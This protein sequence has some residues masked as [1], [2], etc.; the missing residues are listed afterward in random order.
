MRF[1]FVLVTATFFI[2]G[3]TVSQEAAAV[4]KQYQA[5]KLKQQPPV[6]DGRLDETFWQTTEKGGQFVQFQPYEGRQPSQLT[7]FAI[8]YDDNNLYVAYWCYDTSPDSI[9]RRLTRRDEIDGDMVGIDIDSYYDKRTSFGFF[10]NAA[11]VKLDQVTSNNGMAEDKSWDPNWYVATAITAQGWTA[12]M[13]IPLS[14]LRFSDKENRIWGIEVVRQI[15]RKDEM[16][17]WQP[18]PRNAPGSVYMYGELTGIS[19]IKPRRQ[20]DLTPYA[21]ASGEKFE[22]EEGNPYATGK[23]FKY[24]AGLDAKIG[25]TNN[26][27][28]D[29]SVNPDFGQVEADPSQVNLTAFETFFAEKRPFFVEGRNILSMPLMLGDG[30]LANENLFYTRRVGRKPQ[31]YPS[32]SDG[33]YA[34]VP[35]FSRI[36]GAAKISGR[37]ENGWS[38]GLLES[39]AAEEKAEIDLSGEKRYETVEPLTNYLIGTVRKDMNEGNTVI[40]GMI[41][42]TN[43]KLDET[44]L[45][46]LHSG[47]YTAGLDFTQYFKDKAYM[48]MAKTYFSQVNGS[49][50]AITQTQL[51]SAR[52][53]QRPDVT[54]IHLDTTRTSLFGNG[55]TLFFGKLGNSPLQWGWFL[56][57]KT[58]GVELND[59]GYMRSADNIMPIFWAGY[60][61]TKPFGIFRSISMNTD[62]WTTFDFGLNYQGYGGDFSVNASLT[63]LWICGAGLTWNTPSIET[64]LLRGGPAF[65][66][67]GRIQPFV[68]IGTDERK[69]LSLKIAG[70][71]YRAS[72]GDGSMKGMELSLNYKPINALS[73]SL[74]PSFTSSYSNLQYIEQTA[75]GSAD[76]YV[77]GSI[78]QKVLG[79]SLRINLTL[80]PTLTIQYWG[81]P[82]MASGLFSDLKYVTDPMAAQYSDRFHVYTP[83][84][85]ICHQAEGYCD[86]DE[87]LDKVIDYTVGYP[88]FN[89]KEFKSNLVVRWEYRPGSA[90]FL[91]WS[92]GRSGYDP[93]GDFSF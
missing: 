58:P 4:K 55:G 71:G 90:I 57:W 76:R 21:V 68:S 50:E 65:K 37:T 22:K 92:Q 26:L 35:E 83:E 85:L 33:E 18:I 3:I 38:I 63:N 43:R 14:Q 80:T 77:F 82:F 74:S 67:P 17:M 9:S 51:S 52:Y 36:L 66:T 23:D 79:M 60:R 7:E 72:E 16:S 78:N 42:S 31:R 30:D 69:K 70:Y 2:S 24:S 44:T 81:Q 87:N 88:D 53:Y 29:L 59:V 20:I 10:V 47:A 19:D 45:D 32:L 46:D 40:S 34:K 39:V 25:V 13:R 89:V 11:G 61:F 93:Y 62:Q 64:S 6:I 86:V 73:V 49:P 27:T 28:V 84:Q 8:T 75:Y 15:F 56:S 48:L 5:V 91:V 41:T 54:H 12:E 1:L